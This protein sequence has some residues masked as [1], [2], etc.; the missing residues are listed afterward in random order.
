VSVRWLV[1]TLAISSVSLMSL[2]QRL[3]SSL[4][5][6]AGFAGVVAVF[7]AV[8]SIAEGIRQ[9]MES[10]TSSG[11]VMVLRAGSD[12]EMSSVLDREQTQLV[13]DAP[14]VARGPGG[15][16]ASAEVFVVVDVP[17][18]SSGT[19]ANV[20]MRGVEPAAFVVR[21]HVTIVEGRRFTEGRNEVIV[22]RAA[23]RE[24]AGLDLGST[25]RWGENV[26]QVV[27]IFSAD[28]SMYETEIWADARVLQ[29]AYRR[30]SNFQSVIATLESP[31]DFQRLKDAL[32]T[33]SRLEVDVTREADYYADQ[34]RVL[35]Q[36]IGTLGNAIAVLM[37]IGA[38]FG[39]LNTMYS[40]VSA[41]S[42]EIATLRALGFQGGPVLI[43]VMAESLVLAIVGGLLGGAIAYLVADGY[44]TATINFQSFSQVAF[45]LSVT[46]RLLLG[47][48]TYALVMGFVGGIF[49]AIRAVRI[50]IAIGLRDS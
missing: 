40:A 43:S 22:G 45:S 25:L 24:F 33:D 13:K 44:N 19:G 2:R 32:T 3:G 35:R 18:R 28:G 39:A 30:G 29:P 47:G 37:A 12:T 38:T 1:Q 20:P 11:T 26:W 7:V 10:G 23:A 31:N 14:G 16:L 21:P 46:P 49:P 42:Q 36:L 9:V 6:V 15:P 50:P 48:I 17:K 27:G 5:A 4:V 34:S 8:L 41:R